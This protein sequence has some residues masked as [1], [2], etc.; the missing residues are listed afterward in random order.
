MIGCK[1]AVSSTFMQIPSPNYG[2]REKLLEEVFQSGVHPYIQTTGV[3]LFRL[4][5]GR[6][7]EEIKPYLGTNVSYR[8]SYPDAPGLFTSSKPE[9]TSAEVLGTLGFQSAPSPSYVLNYY[10]SGDAVMLDRIQHIGFQQQFLAATGLDRHEFSRDCRFFLE[11][12]GL[13][14][15]AQ[16]LAWASPSGAALGIGGYTFMILPPFS[17][18]LSYKNQ[19]SQVA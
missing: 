12:R 2:Q 6:Q 11:S 8:A 4:V 16:A 9:L 13:I 19:Y 7:L 5:T 3:D 18:A 1:F 14:S 10:F 17:G 15:D